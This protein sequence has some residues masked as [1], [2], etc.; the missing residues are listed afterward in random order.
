MPRLGGAYCFRRVRSQRKS[1]DWGTM[2]PALGGAYECYAYIYF[3]ICSISIALSRFRGSTR[4]FGWFQYVDKWY[5]SVD[6]ESF[7]MSR[8]LIKEEGLL[9]GEYR[10]FSYESPG[11]YSFFQNFPGVKSGPAPFP[12]PR[13]EAQG[14]YSRPGIYPTS[15]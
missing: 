7:K 1:V 9:C 8:R 6:K 2:R 13:V 12:R 14:H 4:D 15:I 10:I 11:I 3:R 5:K